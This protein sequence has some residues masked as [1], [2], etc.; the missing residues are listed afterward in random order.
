MMLIWLGVWLKTLIN[1]KFIPGDPVLIN[2]DAEKIK[3]W[4]QFV[5]ICNMAPCGPEPPSTDTIITYSC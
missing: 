4:V 5:V 3:A 1:I 2:I